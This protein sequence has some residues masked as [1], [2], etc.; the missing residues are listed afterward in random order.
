M[1]KCNELN[2]TVCFNMET[3]WTSN[4]CDPQMCNNR[5]ICIQDEAEC[6]T[7]FHMSL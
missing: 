1:C 4:Q 7:Q 2:E 3:A 6:P 5:G